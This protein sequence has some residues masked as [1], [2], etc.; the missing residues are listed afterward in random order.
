VNV[1]SKVPFHASQMYSSNVT[2]FFTHLVR[3]GRVAID[4]D[5]EIT[6]ETLVAR[7]GQVIHPRVREAL[8]L[9]PAAPTGGR[10]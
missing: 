3:E 9:A 7:D 2:A 5:D 1:P 4:L 6:R 10:P 8:G